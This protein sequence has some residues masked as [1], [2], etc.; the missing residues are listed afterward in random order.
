MLRGQIKHAR[1]LRLHGGLVHLA[2]V[3]EAQQRPHGRGRLQ[4]I[5]LSRLPRILCPVSLQQCAHVCG[6][7]GHDAAVRV[8][9][10]AVGAHKHQVRELVRELWSEKS[11][12]E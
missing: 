10:L 11:M 3:K 9:A 5:H 1:H 8:D 12:D 6:A 4:H 7:S 2:R